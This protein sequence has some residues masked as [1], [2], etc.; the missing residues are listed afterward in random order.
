LGVWWLPQK[1]VLVEKPFGFKLNVRADLFI[2][3]LG[4]IG[5]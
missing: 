3:V 4:W 5:K 2:H 1:L